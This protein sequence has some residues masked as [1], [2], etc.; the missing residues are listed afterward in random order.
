MRA[1]AAAAE[2][3]PAWANSVPASRLI[4]DKYD[5]DKSGVIDKHELLA[6]CKEMGRVLS[7]FEHEN[8]MRVL[9]SNQDGTV[10]YEEFLAWWAHGLSLDVV[11]D[12]R[13][14]EKLEVTRQH[15]V[16][17][18]ALGGGGGGGDANTDDL[19]SVGGLS[20]DT[21]RRTLEARFR[22]GRIC[23]QPCWRR[24]SEPGAARGACGATRPSRPV[25]R[26]G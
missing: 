7:P 3:P 22:E 13:G 1:G 23:V 10:S 9:D 8:A 11:A 12:P 14:A 20:E 19:C 21:L 15:M 6:M 4:F 5:T 25:R 26:H 16:A 18:P 17:K 2:S 24:T